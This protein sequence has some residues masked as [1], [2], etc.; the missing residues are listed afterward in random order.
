MAITI[1]SNNG[2]IVAGG[3]ETDG[4]LILR[5]NDGTNRIHLDAGGGN[6]WVGGNGADGDIVVFAPGGDNETLDQATIHLD[7]GN[8]NIFAGGQGVDGDL[9]LRNGEGD[10]RIRLD[11]SGASAWLGGNGAN[12]DVVVFASGGDNV[13]LDEATIYLDG[14]NGNIRA[15]GSG[16]DGDVILRSDTGQDRI[17]MDASNANIFVGGN[18]ADGDILLFA[19]TGDNVTTETAT[20][21]LNGDAGDIIL[22][23]ADCAEDFQVDDPAAALPGTVMV[24][25]AN[26]HLQVSQT[27]YDRRVAGIVAGAGAYR[28]GIVL[29]R[30][31]GVANAVPIALAGRIFCRVDA[32]YGPV[33]VGDLLTTSPTAG[34][35]MRAGDP[36]KAFGAVI[37]K[38]LGALDRGRG[39]VPMLVALQ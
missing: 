31:P 9:V 35:A 5:A 36:Q 7:G 8:A 3:N 26:A 27:P 21:H 17:R 33:E 37:G 11:A 18:G 39:L 13:T 19:S 2:N 34:H 10:D 28:P 38:S 14:A 30:T 29:G 6:V 15:G 25:G 22:R 16:T 32:E 23:N 20:I 12:G 4:D 1:D 24:I